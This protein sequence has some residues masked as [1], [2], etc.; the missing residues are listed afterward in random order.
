MLIIYT[1]FYTMLLKENSE[2]DV[3][4]YIISYCINVSN[5]LNYFTAEETEA[6]SS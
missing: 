2:H 5:F 3:D 1:Q 4:V 6:Q